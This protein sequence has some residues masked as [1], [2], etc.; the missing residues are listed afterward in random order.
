MAD[1]I[2]E[3][4]TDQVL[5][6][7]TGEVGEDLAQTSSSELIQIRNQFND[8]SR[9]FR[10]LYENG[11]LILAERSK[12][13][14]AAWALVGGLLWSKQF[15]ASDAFAAS[16]RIIHG[17]CEN[18]WG[19][20]YPESRG[21]RSTLLMQIAKWWNTFVVRCSENA[22][23]ENLRIGREELAA[24]QD[25]LIRVTDGNTDQDKIRVLPVLGTLPQ[26]VRS[27]ESNGTPAAMSATAGENGAA[28]QREEASQ[29]AAQGSEQPSSAAPPATPMTA[30]YLDK[31]FEKSCEK[32]RSGQVEEALSSFQHALRG[33]GDYAAQ[34]RGRVLLGELYLR[35][36]LPTHAKRVLQYSHDE[37]EKIRLP[38][39]DP[40]L[41]SRLWSSL[42]QAH[43]KT[44]D[45]KPNDKLLSDLFANLCRIDP[46]TASALE[47][48]KG[49]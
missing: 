37:I 28:P 49:S 5:R 40:K 22:D 17:L 1:A 6:P 45:E 47:P 14:W 39:W 44:K 7:L 27:L 4:L 3:S 24:L 30:D 31:A 15:E 21:L 16:C 2:L 26:I 10:L 19:R 41:C 38:D 35:A 9:D 43:Q 33:F 46:A 36:N 8:S 29:P 20:L 48:I 32:I 42:I 34:F 11:R 13:L 23:P 12:D 25:F 18:Y